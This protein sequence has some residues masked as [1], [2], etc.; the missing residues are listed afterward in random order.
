MMRK[1]LNVKQLKYLEK[2]RENS[3]LLFY[4]L[5]GKLS[6]ELQV[7]K[8]TVRWNLGRLRDSG[9]IIAGDRDAKGVPVKLTEK[10]EIALRIMEREYEFLGKSCCPKALFKAMHKLHIHGDYDEAKKIH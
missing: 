9:M 4:Q 3:G 10:G 8:S 2:V 6:V 5:V 7:P 1:S